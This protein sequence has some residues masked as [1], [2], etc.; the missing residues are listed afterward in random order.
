[1]SVRDGGR[2][3]GVSAEYERRCSISVSEDRDPGRKMFHT[4]WAGCM[5][6]FL[7]QK[8]IGEEIKNENYADY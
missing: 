2:N 7:L 8:K 3:R 5:A 1:M 4:F 6:V